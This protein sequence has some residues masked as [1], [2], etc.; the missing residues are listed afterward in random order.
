MV[1][2]DPLSLEVVRQKHGDALTI[3]EANVFAFLRSA[4]NR[5]EQWDYIYTLGLTDYFDDR[6]MDMFHKLLKAILA[7]QGRIV[8]ANF[9]PNH[10]TAGWMEAVMDWH[11]I[12]RSQG[13]LAD[14]AR[15]AGFSPRTWSEATRSIAWCE[16]THEEGNEA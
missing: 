1:D 9:L 15:K 8:L 5:G 6:A 7:P 16:M 4:K 10:L 2:Q 14:H 12:Y 3:V 11:L 13:Q